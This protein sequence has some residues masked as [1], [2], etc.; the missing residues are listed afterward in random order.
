[1]SGDHEFTLYAGQH[2]D[3]GTVRVAVNGDQLKV[4][5]DTT[6]GWELT[7]MHLWVGDDMATMPQT[8]K[9]NPK[10]GHFPYTHFSEGMTSYSHYIPLADIG[11][12]CPSADAGFYMAAQADVQ[13]EIAQ[14]TWQTEGAWSDGPTWVTRGNWMTYSTIT[15]SCD[16]GEITCETAFA[17]YADTTNDTPE[18][19]EE[20]TCFIDLDMDPKFN[21]WGWTIGSLGAGEYTFDVYAAAG[22]CDMNKGTLVGIL[23]VEYKNNIFNIIDY[24]MH[25]SF[26]IDEAHLYVGCG[27]YE[28][29]PTG[30]NGKYTVAPGQYYV[31]DSI[32][33]GTCMSDIYVV[34]HANVCGYFD[35]E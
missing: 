5:Y 35:E 4:T 24:V 33:D 31:S 17:Y 10:V 3:I 27:E 21:R 28:I 15:L 34:F 26:A 25:D 20:S 6:D 13:K 32:K 22:Q 14:D 2:I 9:G 18:K 19:T 12:A 1:M 11:F 16:C 29:L 7:A 30:S 23:T 8:N